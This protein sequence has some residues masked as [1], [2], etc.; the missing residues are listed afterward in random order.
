MMAY[1]FGIMLSSAWNRCGNKC[2]KL[3]LTVSLLCLLIFTGCVEKW[4]SGFKTMTSCYAN[5]T[6]IERADV[7]GQVTDCIIRNSDENDEIIVW[8]NKNILYVLS[9]RMPASKYSYQFPLI[10]ISGEIE[11]EFFNDLKQNIPKL[12]VIYRDDNRIFDF[13]NEYNYQTVGE[14]EDGVTVMKRDD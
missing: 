6:N 3:I 8:G 13:L 1:P 11:S 2:S 9:G 10:D 14:F 5:R 12:I 7:I 4:F